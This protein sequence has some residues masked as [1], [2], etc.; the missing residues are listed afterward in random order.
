MEKLVSVIVPIYNREKYLHRC[1]DSILAQ[2]YRNIEVI[3]VDDGSTDN[4]PQI[5]DEYAQKDNR[6][7]VFHIPNGGVSN[8]RN[9]GLDNAQGE[10][11]FFVDSD[12]YIKETHVQDLLPKEDEDFVYGGFVIVKNEQVIEETKNPKQ[13]YCLEQEADI[14][15]FIS[16]MHHIWSTCV[17]V[18]KKSIIKTYN[19][20]F[21]AASIAEDELFN[22]TYLQFCKNIR[23]IDKCSYYYER[24][25]HISLVGTYHPER[26]Y[27]VEKICK[28]K[29]LLVKKAISSVRWYHWQSAFGHYNKWIK[30][31][32]KS[33]KK[34]AKKQLKE[35][36]NNAYFRECIPYIRKHGSLDEKIETYFM[37]YY[38][39]KLFKPV[40][41]IIKFLY[42]F[43]K[44][45]KVG[46]K[47]EHNT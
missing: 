25:D 4:S 46:D 47:H 23:F 36:Y 41:S 10:Y 11:I 30:N 14:N 5:C 34:D 8:A 45:N 31:G 13:F 22:F 33:V 42:K 43:K 39:H 18:Y 19:I 28:A 7:K 21:V 35:T 12:D 3:C 40:Y 37:G 1:L 24:G 32:S 2:T 26:L 44:K 17:G 16:F 9:T 15:N 27:V 29:E 38:K 6:V 20:Q